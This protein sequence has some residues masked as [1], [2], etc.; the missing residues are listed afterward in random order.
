MV[1]PRTILNS[2]SGSV[3]LSV[4]CRKFSV[5]FGNVFFATDVKVNL[6]YN[7][8]NS[9]QLNSIQPGLREVIVGT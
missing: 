7:K 3:G 4:W 6:K 9:T 2:V 5:D 1:R 8:K